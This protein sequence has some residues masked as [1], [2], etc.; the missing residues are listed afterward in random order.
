MRKTLLTIA[1]LAAASM[2]AAQSST[3]PD[4][5]AQK[6]PSTAKAKDIAKD[7]ELNDFVVTGSRR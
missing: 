4:T 2:A 6:T 3:P 5:T 7:L 1:A